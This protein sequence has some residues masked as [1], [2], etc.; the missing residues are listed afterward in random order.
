MN[1]QIKTHRTSAE[2][3]VYEDGYERAVAGIPMDHDL[4]AESK[5]ESIYK[6]GYDDGLAWM[7]SQ[8]S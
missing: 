2:S 5:Y 1:N 4:Y 7:E 6:A 3:N 8:E